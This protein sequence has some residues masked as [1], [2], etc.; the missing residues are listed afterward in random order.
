MLTIFAI[1][2]PFAGHINIIQ[3]NA[4]MSWKLLGPRCE[5]ILFGDEEGTADVA[6]DFD[7]LHIPEVNRN[8]FGTPFINDLFK[9]AQTL[10]KHKVMCYVNSD[11]II[12]NN[13]IKAIENIP[14]KDFVL[15]GRRWNVSI[16]E[17]IDF[18][19]KEWQQSLNKLYRDGILGSIWAMDFFIFPTSSKMTKIPPFAVG[20]PGWDNWFIFRARQL[21]I[22]VIDATRDIQIAHQN[23]NY[24]H[25]PFSKGNSY[26]GPEASLNW[27]LVGDFNKDF[28]LLDATHIMTK[29][30]VKLALSFPYIKRRW[31]KITVLKPHYSLL[32]IC[33]SKILN[34]L[35]RLHH[36]ILSN[37]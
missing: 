3:R 29:Q 5:I 12:C 18:S 11:I 6:K 23:H 27:Q 1:P 34:S 30:S 21:N 37:S 9:K 28:N 10:A 13:F 20:R 4:I 22:P 24:D 7:I 14:F 32:I 15:T 2:K 17:L 33:L 8:E 36:K 26:E 25:V 31:Q 19:S 16:N 35:R